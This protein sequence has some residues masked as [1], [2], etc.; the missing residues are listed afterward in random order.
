[1]GCIFKLLKVVVIDVGI[2]VYL[3]IIYV[4]KFD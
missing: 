4:V 3:G 1:M 2:G